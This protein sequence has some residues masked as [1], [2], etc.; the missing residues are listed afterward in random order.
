[1]EKEGIQP[2]FALDYRMDDDE[3]NGIAEEYGAF[4]DGEGQIEAD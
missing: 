2:C 1:V 4:D 3:R